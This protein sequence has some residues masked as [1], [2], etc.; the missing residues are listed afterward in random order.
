MKYELIHFSD[1]LMICYFVKQPPFV[2]G[3]RDKI[4]QKIIKDKVKLPG[5]LSSEAH[6]LLKGVILHLHVLQYLFGIFYNP[7]M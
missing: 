3:N 5:F 4:Q 6:S 7:F 1:R 2:G